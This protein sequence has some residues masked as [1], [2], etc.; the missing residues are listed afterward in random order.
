MFFANAVDA[1]VKFENL[2]QMVVG[3]RLR[4][5][6]VSKGIGYAVIIMVEREELVR[7]PIMEI[8]EAAEFAMWW[9]NEY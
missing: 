6:V 7:V 9:Q 2:R 3:R 8:Q 1:I 4:S 5:R